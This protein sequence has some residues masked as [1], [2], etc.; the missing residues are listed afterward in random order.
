MNIFAACPGDPNETICH[1]RTLVHSAGAL[2]LWSVSFFCCGSAR[3]LVL[4]ADTMPKDLSTIKTVPG[5]VKCMWAPPSLVEPSSEV[6]LVAVLCGFVLFSE[7]LDVHKIQY[8]QGGSNVSEQS[9]LPTLPK[10]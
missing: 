3:A 6:L 7:K 8:F 10:N 2:S 5:V 1:Q 4:I 9:P